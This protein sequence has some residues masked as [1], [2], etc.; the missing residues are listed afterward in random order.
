[1]KTGKPEELEDG[2]GD[3]KQIRGVARL[4]SPPG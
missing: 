4:N 2:C 1:M 3:G